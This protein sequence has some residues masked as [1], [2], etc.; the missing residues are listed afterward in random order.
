MV[1]TS[2]FGKQI[3]VSENY[4]ERKFRGKKKRHGQDVVAKNSKPLMLSKL[5]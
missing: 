4:E 5:F 2:L 1:F 3:I